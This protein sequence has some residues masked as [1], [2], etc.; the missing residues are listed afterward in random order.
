MKNKNGAVLQVSMTISH[1]HARE[2]SKGEN[3]FRPSATHALWAVARDTHS[4]YT[5]SKRK[6]SEFEIAQSN[7]SSAT[8]TK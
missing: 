1:T 8:P 4:T 2:T 7:G 6:K 5:Q 3:F